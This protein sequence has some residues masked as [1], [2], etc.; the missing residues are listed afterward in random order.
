MTK[1]AEFPRPTPAEL[2]ILRVLW[3]RGPSSV[4]LVH[5]ELS[6]DRPTGYT[7]VLKLMQIMTEKGL[8]ERDESER[9][10]IYHPRLN[11]QKTQRQMVKD[12]IDRAFGGDASQL[13]MQALSSRRATPEELAAIREILDKL[14]QD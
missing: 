5:Q 11:E 7:T 1:Q 13:V 14:D 9:A 12:L 2:S 6:K 4:R 8:V 10:H 3:S